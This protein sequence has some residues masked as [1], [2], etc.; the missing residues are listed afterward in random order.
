MQVVTEN[1]MNLQLTNKYFPSSKEIILQAVTQNGLSLQYV[2]DDSLRND[3][4][5]IFQA[6]TQNGMSLK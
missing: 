5:I 3:R 4:E 1:G 6:I 2:I